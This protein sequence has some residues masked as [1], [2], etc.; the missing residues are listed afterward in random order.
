MPVGEGFVAG[1]GVITTG[2]LAFGNSIA[3]AGSGKQKSRM[4][5]NIRKS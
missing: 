3:F 2:W 4:P 5:F 1:E